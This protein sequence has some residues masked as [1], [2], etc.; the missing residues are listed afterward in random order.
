MITKLQ[1]AQI[2][3]SKRLTLPLDQDLLLDISTPMILE[4]AHVMENH[5]VKFILNNK[6]LEMLRPKRQFSQ[7]LTSK[8][9]LVWL[10]QLLLKRMLLQ[11][12]MK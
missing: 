5:Q 10:T 11:F 7:A 3:Q 6:S 4:W 1:Q 12:S 2:R 9:L 8:L